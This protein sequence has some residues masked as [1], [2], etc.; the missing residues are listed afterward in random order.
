MAFKKPAHLP[1]FVKPFN[2]LV[3]L[4]AGKHFYALLRHRGRTSGKLYATP[5]VAWP[6]AGGML[7]PLSWGTKSDWFRNT[8]AAGG[9]E[10]QRAGRWYRCARP[11]LIERTTVRSYL[12]PMTRTVSCLFPVQQFVLL[13]EV[14]P[15]G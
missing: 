13:R 7:V 10:L 12:P 1:A 3:R 9:C 15:L 6:T 11:A 14:T 5:V 2:R 4:F 8:M